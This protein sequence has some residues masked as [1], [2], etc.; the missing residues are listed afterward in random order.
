MSSVSI[1]D[2]EKLVR[3]L[4]DVLPVLPLKNTVLFPYI[5]LPLSVGGE[6]SAVAVD[7]ALADHRMLMLVAQ[8]D[9]TTEDPGERD[10]HPV[11]T[12]ALIMRMLK[13]PDGRMRILVQGLA[14]AAVDHLAH[15]EPYLAARLQR[16]PEPAAPEDMETQAL[17]R[18]V[19]DQLDE[20]A[21]LGRSI[22]PEV[23]VVATNLEDPGRLADLAASNL[24]LKLED[25]QALLETAD[26]LVR[27]R[28][29]SELLQREIQLLPMQQEISSEA[30]GE[31]DRSQ[32]EYFLR[33]QL[34][35]IQQSWARATSSPRRSPATAPR[36]PSATCR[37]R[38]ARSSSARSAASSAR[39]PT[40]PRAP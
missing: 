19:K 7:R 4:P 13:L 14:R 24:E 39:I 21:G 10:L 31:M 18:I 33:Q 2:Q 26:G 15:T 30:R 34:R 35:A 28:R 3:S 40:A 1:S 29:V 27:L 22:S 36:P 5:I 9:P 23:M 37:R 11:G 16:M 8:R 25:A 38:P 6:K 20:V 12:A 32:R 17:V